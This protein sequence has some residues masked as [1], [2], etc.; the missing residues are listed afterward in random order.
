M[1]DYNHL[2]LN[3]NNYYIL[4]CDYLHLDC[5]IMKNILKYSIVN[6]HNFKQSEL[7]NNTIIA[8]KSKWNELNINL[9]NNT[10]E[11]YQHN[12]WLNKTYFAFH[13][14]PLFATNEFITYPYNYW[15]KKKQIGWQ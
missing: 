7:E 6:K 4:F 8:S 9:W 5:N 11:R 14:W 3:K 12:Q 15:I 1:I 10:L 13:Q 2:I